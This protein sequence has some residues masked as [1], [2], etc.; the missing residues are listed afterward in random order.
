MH[1]EFLDVLLL[2]EF[3]VFSRFPELEQ[4]VDYFLYDWDNSCISITLSQIEKQRK[5]IEKHPRYI[6]LVSLNTKPKYQTKNVSEIVSF[7][8]QET[9]LRTKNVLERIWPIITKKL[10]KYS[11]EKINWNKDA[12]PIFLYGPIHK[13][14]YEVPWC[15]KYPSFSDNSLLKPALKRSSIFSMF[16]VPISPTQSSNT[17]IDYTLS[18]ASED[19]YR[20]SISP[21]PNL[22]LPAPKSKF[23]TEIVENSSISSKSKKSSNHT[24]DSSIGKINPLSLYTPS[25]I[26]SPNKHKIRFNNQVEQCIVLF[27]KEKELLSNNMHNIHVSSK[28]QSRNSYVIK[29]APTHLNDYK[30]KRNKR[31]NNTQ[32]SYTSLEDGF[33]RKLG[34]INSILGSYK[35]IYPVP[36]DVKSN[37]SQCSCS[38]HTNN[39]SHNCGSICPAESKYSLSIPSNTCSKT[40]FEE[41][42]DIDSINDLVYKT[43]EGDVCN[44]ESSY[45]NE[46]STKNQF[47]T[48]NTLKS[49]KHI[50]TRDD[51]DTSVQPVLSSIMYGRKK[52]PDVNITEC[53]FLPLSKD[54]NDTIAEFAEERIN[55]T[56]DAVKWVSAFISNYTPL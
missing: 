14:H 37:K 38:N 19:D 43:I 32:N 52:V 6:E 41:T 29:L 25:K 31:R 11:P 20:I 9:N 7:E 24:F 13:D 53:L 34:W 35:Y 8:E 28:H 44:T 45:V 17:L 2:P 5:E 49:Q 16:G 30:Y 54:A 36:D 3:D 22:P 48:K 15:Y 42:Q 10:E 4:R 1:K 56:Y 40:Q 27:P 33:T 26:K 51:D 18:T 47:R 55:T 21:E 50:N 39:V 12:D 23:S 46:N